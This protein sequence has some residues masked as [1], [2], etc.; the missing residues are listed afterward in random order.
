MHPNPD[1]IRRATSNP[2][3]LFAQAEMSAERGDWR[4]VAAAIH[5]LLR[6][7]V[8]VSFGSPTQTTVK[9]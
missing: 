4:N 9:V 3:V 2:V 6:L 7:G 8:R 5:H 1:T